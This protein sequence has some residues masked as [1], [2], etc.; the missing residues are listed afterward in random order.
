MLR[1]V[2]PNR[3]FQIQFSEFADFDPAVLFEWRQPNLVIPGIIDPSL[4]F[5]RTVSFWRRELGLSAFSMRTG[6]L[7]AGYIQWDHANPQSLPIQVNDEIVIDI[8]GDKALQVRELLRTLAAQVVGGPFERS[9]GS[10]YLLSKTLWKQQPVVGVFTPAN[11]RITEQSLRS[12]LREQLAVS[13]VQSQ[14]HSDV[15]GMDADAKTTVRFV[16]T[17]SDARKAALSLD[18]KL[19]LT[20]LFA[21]I[22]EVP[23]WSRE[24]TALVQESTPLLVVADI[25]DIHRRAV[26]ALRL[27]RIEVGNNIE[28]HLPRGKHTI[29]Y[30]GTLVGKKIRASQGKPFHRLTI[31]VYE[32]LRLDVDVLVWDE[33]SWD[34]GDWA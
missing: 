10:W 23:G 9:D 14:V 1:N 18:K 13:E 32:E 4:T 30:R 28:I 2:F 22:Q 19:N 11:Y 27:N 8:P 34:E 16:T 7:P 33:G 20:S 25:L 15:V 29:A 3:D 24:Q 21:I 5:D 31:W 26:D 12:E 17:E 6:E